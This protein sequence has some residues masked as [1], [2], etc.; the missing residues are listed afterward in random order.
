MKTVKF[1]RAGNRLAGQQP[2]EVGVAK[3]A[4]ENAGRL[5]MSKR[6]WQTNIQTGI[7]RLLS[8]IGQV[9]Q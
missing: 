5:A 2:G 3:V 9:D 4:V 8:M 6:T 7:K 1:K